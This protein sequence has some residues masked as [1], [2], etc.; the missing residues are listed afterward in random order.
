MWLAR[1][2]GT[3]DL[4]W[5]ATHSPLQLIPHVRAAVE[6][7]LCH[8]VRLSRQLFCDNISVH[9]S[10]VTVTLNFADSFRTASCHRQLAHAVE[11]EGSS[12]Q[13]Q[14]AHRSATNPVTRSDHEQLVYNRTERTGGFDCGDFPEENAGSNSFSSVLKMAKKTDCAMS[15]RF[16]SW[17]VR[18]LTIPSRRCER[19]TSGLLSF[20]CRACS[21]VRRK[22]PSITLRPRFKAA[23]CWRPAFHAL[24][25]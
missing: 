10:R 1:L 8:A 11:N 20:S 22:A 12:R 25:T 13:P 7:C 18:V 14:S 9:S 6:S 24:P 15:G 3:C 2:D 4:H 17:L 16:F 19:P 21:R 5:V 23:S